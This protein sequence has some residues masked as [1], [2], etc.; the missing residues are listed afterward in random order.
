MNPFKYKPAQIKKAAVAAA[1]AVTEAIA[2]GLLDG[3]SEKVALC[4]LAAA[5]V[6]G[7]FAAQNAD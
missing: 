6:Y 7:V 1:T 5:G 2:L 3:T 4:G